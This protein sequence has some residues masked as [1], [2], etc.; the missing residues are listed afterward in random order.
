MW[1][2]GEQSKVKTVILFM[3]PEV[4][5]F[6]CIL[7][8]TQTSTD[9]MWEGTLL[10][11]KDQKVRALEVFFETGYTTIQKENDLK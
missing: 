6:V 10:K 2:T 1:L 7:L 5:S 8:I 9:L 3:T 4:A 11:V